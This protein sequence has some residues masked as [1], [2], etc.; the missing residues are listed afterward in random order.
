LCPFCF[1]RIHEI[2]S[3]Q[4]FGVVKSDVETVSVVV[5]VGN[6]LAVF[7]RGPLLLPEAELKPMVPARA[8]ARKASRN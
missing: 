2:Q 5:R 8:T 7:E 4:I 3:N 1:R 6:K